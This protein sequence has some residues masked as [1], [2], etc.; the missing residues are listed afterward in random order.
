MNLFPIKVLGYQTL[1]RA[2]KFLGQIVPLPKPTL[3]TGSGSSLELCSAIGQMGY[4]KVLIVTCR[5]LILFFP[6]YWRI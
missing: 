2:L 5:R 4:N 3:F 1:M 6:H